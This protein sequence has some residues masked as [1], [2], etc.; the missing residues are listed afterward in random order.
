MSLLS[1]DLVLASLEILNPELSNSL[2]Q[3]NTLDIKNNKYALAVGIRNVEKAVK[4]QMSTVKAICNQSGGKGDIIGGAREEK[5]WADI[6][7]FPWDLLKSERVVCKAGV[8]VSEIPKILENLDKLSEK[9]GVKTY[10]STRAGSGICIIAMEGENASIL[11][12]V[13]SLRTL[14]ST[15]GGHLVIQDAPSVIKSEIDVWGDIGSGEVIM[16]RI[17]SNFD[18]DNLFNPGRFI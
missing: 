16:K 5:L 13:V 9:S 2:A 14:L 3:N 4:D 8:L 11:D 10:V 12:T 18:P 6:R 7:D 15:I 1:S 17:K